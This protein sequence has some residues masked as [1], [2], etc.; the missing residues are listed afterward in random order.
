MCI[1]LV[2]QMGQMFT[3][4]RVCKRMIKECLQKYTVYTHHVYIHTHVNKQKGM[5]TVTNSGTGGGDY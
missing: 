3:E 2:V 4:V 1:T 5:H